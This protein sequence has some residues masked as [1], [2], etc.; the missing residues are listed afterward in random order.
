MKRPPCM[1]LTLAFMF[2]YCDPRLE[3]VLERLDMESFVLRELVTSNQGLPN[4]NLDLVRSFN[5]RFS[6]AIW[7]IWALIRLLGFRRDT[8]KF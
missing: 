2:Y 1:D 8:K 4:S 5:V 6:G 3:C 7:V